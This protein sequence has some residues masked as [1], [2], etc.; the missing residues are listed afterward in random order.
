MKL[1]VSWILETDNLN[2][3]LAVASYWLKILRNEFNLNKTK[4]SKI[5][6]FLVKQRSHVSSKIK[7]NI[8]KSISMITKKIIPRLMSTQVS[9]FAIWYFNHRCHVSPF[10]IPIELLL[11][12]LATNFF[13]RQFNPITAKL[14]FPSDFM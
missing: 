14:S 11:H 10:D 7:Y 2:S 12:T 9:L 5:L 3:T 6:E 4:R 13:T 8:I 1:L